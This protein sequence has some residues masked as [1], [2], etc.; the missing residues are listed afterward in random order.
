[1]GLIRDICR[2]GQENRKEPVFPAFA[3]TPNQTLMFTRRCF[4]S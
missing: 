1:M 4:L 2:A 3:Y